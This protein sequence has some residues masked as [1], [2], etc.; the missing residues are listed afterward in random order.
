MGPVRINPGGLNTGTPVGIPSLN[1]GSNVFSSPN[2]PGKSSQGFPPL[3]PQVINVL[4]VNVNV[5]TLFIA[6]STKQLISLVV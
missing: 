4:Y 2:S 1:T 3:V 5:F 6:S